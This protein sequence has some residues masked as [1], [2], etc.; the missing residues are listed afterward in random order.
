MVMMHSFQNIAIVVAWK[1]E[2]AIQVVDEAKL[3]VANEEALLRVHNILANTLALQVQSHLHLGK[4]VRSP[5]MLSFPQVDIEA[6]CLEKLALGA[7]VELHGNQ[8]QVQFRFQQ[9]ASL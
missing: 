8:D 1:E 7:P 9:K 6:S 2:L 3:A 4:V 5:M